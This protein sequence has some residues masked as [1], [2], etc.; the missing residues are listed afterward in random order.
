MRVVHGRLHNAKRS[1][2]HAFN[3]MFGKVANVI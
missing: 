2:Y 3:A 1:F